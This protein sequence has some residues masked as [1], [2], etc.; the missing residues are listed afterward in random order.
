MFEAPINWVQL[1]LRDSGRIAAMERVAKRRRTMYGAAQVD[2]LM[3]HRLNASRSEQRKR[4]LLLIQSGALW[5]ATSLHKAGYLVDPVCQ[6]CGQAP[7][8]LAHLFWECPA[9]HECRAQVRKELKWHWQH[10][11]T[12]LALHGIP[13]EPNG[14]LNGAIWRASDC[15][16]D[17][18]ARYAGELQSDDRI[19]WGR[20]HEELTCEV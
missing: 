6:W 20:V 10:L 7:E 18:H 17:P 12:C 11:P 3:H 4:D 8:T 5:T 9:H 1:V 14:E 13:V 19:S 15:P 2:F 16:E